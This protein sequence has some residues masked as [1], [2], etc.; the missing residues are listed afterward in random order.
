[1]T[2]SLLM[3]HT[4]YQRPRLFFAAFIVALT[5][6]NWLFPDIMPF[7][8]GFG[9]EGYTIYKP[10]AVDLK[11]YLI[12]TPVN[13][14]SVQR[15]FP[16]VLL[17]TFFKVFGIAFSD[18]NMILFFQIF[19]LLLALL[20][21]QVWSALG[22][23]LHLELPGQWVGYLSLIINFA[24]L[25]HDFYIPFTYDRLALAS[26]LISFY[27]YLSNRPGWL[28]LNSLIALTIWPT[29]LFF[30]SILLLIPATERIPTTSNPLLARFWAVGIASAICGLFTVVIYV[31]HIPAPMHLATPIY[32]LI[33]IGILVTAVYLLYAQASLARQLLPAWSNLL[34]WLGHLLRP[35]LAWAGVVLLI[36]AYRLLTHKLGD[37]TQALLSPQAY[38]INLTFGALQRPA[39]FIF[40]HIIYYGLPVLL[41][42]LFWRRALNAV[43]RLGLGSGVILVVVLIQ[44]VNSETRQ[45]ANVLPLL[46][47]LAALLADELRPRPIVVALTAFVTFIISKGWLPFNRFSP[48]YGQPDDIFPMFG[49]ERGNFLEWPQQVYFMNF[50]PWTATRYLALQAGILL[51]VAAL[52]Y[53]W[54]QPS[55]DAAKHKIA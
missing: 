50:G 27:C 12:T 7:H 29:A 38:A 54:W 30:N 39:Q 4:I 40:C 37:P 2:E 23:K 6:L 53:W 15:I 49:F 43:N 1:M 47:L 51:V 9:F 42:L 32:P 24:T 41:L 33:P 10:L 55:K 44:A 5:C 3:I 8:Q 22:K 31:R 46:A 17:H 36:G 25:K 20:I 21:I 45:M 11:Q 52:L 14:Y 35:R 28:L 13:S 48:M 18:V 34:P 16:Y 19:F 26:G